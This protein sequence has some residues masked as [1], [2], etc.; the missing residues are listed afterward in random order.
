MMKPYSATLE[1][2]AMVAQLIDF[3]VQSE[4]VETVVGE[5]PFVGEQDE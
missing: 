4:I 3:C 2:W 1:N 5:A